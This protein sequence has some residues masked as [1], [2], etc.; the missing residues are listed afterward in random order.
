MHMGIVPFN[1]EYKLSAKRVFNSAALQNV[2]DQL[3]VY[4]RQHGFDVERG[5]QESQ[6]K[7][8]TVPEYKAMRED[9]NLDVV[10]NHF[11]RLAEI[12]EYLHITDE[13]ARQYHLIR[14]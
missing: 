10:G 13:E 14:G 5:I 1:D 3:P 12:M 7:S 11:E 4:L 2:Q 6:H 8:L 9:L